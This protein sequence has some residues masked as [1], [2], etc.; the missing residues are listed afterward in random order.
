MNHSFTILW[1]I[2]FKIMS[3][4]PQLMDQDLQI[5]SKNYDISKNVN[6]KELCEHCA[7]CYPHCTPLNIM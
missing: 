2:K 6:I 4:I 3:E 7:F 1:K 5:V